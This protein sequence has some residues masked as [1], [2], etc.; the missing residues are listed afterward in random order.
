MNRIDCAEGTDCAAL[1]S[2]VSWSNAWSIDMDPPTAT[3]AGAGPVK[4][5]MAVVA[6]GVT[7]APAGSFPRALGGR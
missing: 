3:G 5:D 1:C 2:V 4:V 6:A 7:A